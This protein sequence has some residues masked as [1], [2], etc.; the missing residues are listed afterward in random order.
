MSQKLYCIIHFNDCVHFRTDLFKVPIRPVDT[1][2]DEINL[3]NNLMNRVWFALVI[4]W[5]NRTGIGMFVMIFKIKEIRDTF[6]YFL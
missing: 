3:M 1:N 6:E 5:L 4:Y 2:F